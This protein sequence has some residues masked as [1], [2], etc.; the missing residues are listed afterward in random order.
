[1]L[2]QSEAIA[3]A[4][5]ASARGGV[6]SI[7]ALVP[8]ALLAGRRSIELGPDKARRLI[9]QLPIAGISGRGQRGADPVPAG[10]RLR[11]LALGVPSPGTHPRRG[12]PPNGVGARLQ[13]VDPVKRSG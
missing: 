12:S 11:D 1:M 10:A 4:R 7:R 2:P 5:V 9:R 3:N 8:L 13:I 6:F